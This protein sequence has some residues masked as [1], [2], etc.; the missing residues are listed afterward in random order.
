MHR[1]G[2]RAAML[3]AAISIVWPNIALAH[4]EWRDGPLKECSNHSSVPTPLIGNDGR[5]EFMAPRTFRFVF[6]LPAQGQS[7]GYERSSMIR[8]APPKLEPA[9]D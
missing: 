7:G 4:S 9:R 2:L 8:I 1:T 5:P 6:A 3:A